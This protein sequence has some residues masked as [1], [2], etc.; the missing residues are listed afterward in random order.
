[1][2]TKKKTLPQRVTPKW[3]AGFFDGEGSAKVYSKYGSAK[4]RI[5]QKDPTI[6]RAIQA[7]YGGRLSP[8][9]HQN[10]MVLE[11]R[12]PEAYRLLK[13]IHPHLLTP[14]KKKDVEDTLEF[15]RQLTAR[16]TPRSRGSTRS[17]VVR[18]SR[19]TMRLWG[20]GRARSSK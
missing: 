4:V 6:L 1:M 3:L 11:F 16:G 14:L 19:R 10:A 7:R 12:Y 8:Y 18:G 9:T 13:A 15:L 5:G 17:R 20:N 2:T